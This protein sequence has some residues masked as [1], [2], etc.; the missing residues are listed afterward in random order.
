MKYLLSI[1]TLF[2]S[3]TTLANTGVVNV[4]NWSDYMP[5]AVVDEFEKE[6]GIKVNY[7][8]YDSN[9]TMYA[10]LKAEPT[11]SYDVIVPSDY[12]VDKL[13]KQG[14]LQKLDKSQL[15]NFKNLNPALL[16]RAY[17][18]NNDYS[19]PYLWGTVGIVVNSKYLS[20]D[21][22]KNWSD[23]WNS[24][25]RN[26]VLMLNDMRMVFGVTLM[27]LG[28]PINDTNPEHIKQAYL[29]L[30]ELM[31]NIKL[32]NSDSADNLYIDEDINLGMNFSGDTF[33]DI[34]DNADLKY[35]YPK[36]GFPMWIDNLA[37]PKGAPHLQNAYIFLNFLMRP[38]IAKQIALVQRYSSPNMEA[39]K[40]LPPSWRDNPIF[41]PSAKVLKH[42]QSHLD[43][44]DADVIYA[45]YWEKLKIEE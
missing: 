25:Y 23:L 6:T 4:F 13:R 36:E 16:N 11:V 43:L 7:S 2:I 1:F 28:Y 35:I 8:Q 21:S 34:V 30:K 26:Q 40:L 22:I 24:K 39:A 15:P 29:K 44:G 12:F 19:L 5:Q 10:K 38:D 32:F 18:R 14:M 3:L 17:D 37:I 41:N 31:T 42:G 33:R 27:S 9:E 45:K 20:P